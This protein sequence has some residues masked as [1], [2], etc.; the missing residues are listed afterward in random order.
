MLRFYRWMTAPDSR[1][2]SLTASANALFSKPLV[3]DLL[4][5]DAY[6]IDAAV[7]KKD[8]KRIVGALHNPLVEKCRIGGALTPRRFS[9]A[10]EIGFLPGVTDNVGRTVVEI[11][12]DLIGRKLKTTEAAYT[13]R[14]LF[15][16]GSISEKQARAFA[17]TLHNPLI[18]RASILSA[19]D[20]KKR[21]GFAAKPP[22]VVLRT[23]A[24]ADEVHLEIS[25]ADLSLLG[26]QGIKNPDGV[27]R[28]PLALSLLQ[29]KAIRDYFRKEKRNPTDVELESLAQTWSEHCKHTIFADPLDDIEEGI[30]RRYIKGATNRIRKAKGKRDFCVSVF[31][32][33]S[34]AIVFDDEYL[35]THKVETHNSPSALDPYG[36][37][38]TGIVGVNRDTLG[39]GLGAKPVANVYGFCVGNPKEKRA[40]YRDQ[41]RKNPMF[42]PERILKGIVAGVNA[43]GNESGIPTPQGFVSL[44]DRYRG[45]PL[46]F[47]G[48]VGLIPRKE[49]GRCIRNL[50]EEETTSS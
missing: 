32:D 48:T 2:K 38:I 24:V 4:V 17:T 30:Y 18:E 25:D 22:R 47:V 39:F 26:K 3:K 28:G 44:D 33:N 8:I 7:M 23:R 9:Y 15:M 27:R 12:E 5:V 42:S 45:K 10:I 14:I 36:G 1:G 41:E 19:V 34:G 20:Y 31:T 29:L 37:A 46:V 49:K 50:P 6:L 21:G 16:D 11:A 13:S 43:G 40:L 35:I